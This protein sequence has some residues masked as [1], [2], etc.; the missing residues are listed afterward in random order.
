MPEAVG[1]KSAVMSDNRAGAKAA[2]GAPREKLG[3]SAQEF[4]QMGE[5]GAM[6][7]RQGNLEKARTIFE[8]LV[9]L[10]PESAAAHAALGALLT[11]TEQFERAL[12]HLGRAVELDPKEIA[13]YVNRAE[14]FI[15]QGRAEE[16]VENLKRA[17]ELDP[18][19]EDPAANRARAMAL[20]LAEA[21]KA[22]GITGQP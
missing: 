8:G 1:I 19:E 10:D 17:V 6:F 5:M 11:R 16:A 20:G 22:R 3:V 7:Y 21:L 9:E 2:G 18:R 12:E 13:P 4:Q 14:I 15:R